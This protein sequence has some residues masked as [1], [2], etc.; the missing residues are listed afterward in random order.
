MARSNIDSD[1]ERPLWGKLLVQLS[2]TLFTD[3][4]DVGRQDEL[5][6]TLRGHIGLIEEALDRL[7]GEATEAHQGK[8]VYD[9]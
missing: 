1:G 5:E 3:P 4:A 9:Y 2:H 6:G 8:K 7:E